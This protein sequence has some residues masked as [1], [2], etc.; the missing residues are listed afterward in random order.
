MNHY[1]AD[2]KKNKTEQEQLESAASH[3]VF[4]LLSF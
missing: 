1:F 3:L 4:H 2:S